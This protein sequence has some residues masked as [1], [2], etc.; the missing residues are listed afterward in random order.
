M[1]DRSDD[2]APS[3][4]GLRAG[5]DLPAPDAPMLGGA[6]RPAS[7]VRLQPRDRSGLKDLGIYLGKPGGRAW[8]P[9]M[10]SAALEAYVER[11]LEDGTP[12]A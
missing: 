2:L 10:G 8:R 4:G 12:E 7:A 5:A 3:L 1:D 9:D 11:L 6:G